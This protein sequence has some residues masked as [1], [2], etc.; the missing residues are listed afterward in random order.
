MKLVPIIDIALKRLKISKFV[1]IKN[2]NIDY[3][4]QIMIYS[5]LLWRRC[6]YL[7][8]VL[9]VYNWFEIRTKMF[10]IESYAVVYVSIV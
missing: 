3:L 7:Q 2:G 8:T 9:M 5:I 4:N 6:I 1:L 10:F